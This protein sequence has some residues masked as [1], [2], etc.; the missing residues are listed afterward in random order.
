[1]EV[2]FKVGYICCQRGLKCWPTAYIA[3]F[4][5]TAIVDYRLLFAVPRKTK[6]CFP[7]PFAANKLKF[8]VAFFICS[9]QTEISV[10]HYY[11]FLFIYIWKIELME[12]GNFRL[13]AANRK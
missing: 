3:T 8:A 10:F 7:F 9:K 5:E 6:F 2:L 4:A 1:V 13:F 12:N 11:C